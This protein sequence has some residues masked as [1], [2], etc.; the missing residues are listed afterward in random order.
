MR[1]PPHFSH[2]RECLIRSCHMTFPHSFFLHQSFPSVT[3]E[4]KLRVLLEIKN[5]AVNSTLC[6]WRVWKSKR[7]WRKYREV[8]IRKLSFT[9]IESFMQLRSFLWKLHKPIKLDIFSTGNRILNY[10][11]KNIEICFYFIFLKPKPISQF[12]Q[13]KKKSS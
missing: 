13:N 10:N 4:I 6:N 11:K 8:Q 12:N 3:L 9:V 2:P 1:S 7:P 5:A